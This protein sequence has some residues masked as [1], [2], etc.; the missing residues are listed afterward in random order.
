MMD[1]LASLLG[2]EIGAPLGRWIR[3]HLPTG[4][5]QRGR[6][7]R[8]AAKVFGSRRRVIETKSATTATTDGDP[9]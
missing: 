7:H 6:D 9:E 2:V 4:S 5:S 8:E 1:W 3:K